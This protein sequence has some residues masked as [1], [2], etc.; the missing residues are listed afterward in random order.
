MVNHNL[1]FKTTI[2]DNIAFFSRHFKQIQVVEL[3]L[4]DEKK[5]WF[6]EQCPIFRWPNKEGNDIH[7]SVSRRFINE[8]KGVH[9]CRWYSFIYIYIYFDIY[10]HIFIYTIYIYIHIF[11]YRAKRFA[12]AM[13][14]H[15]ASMTFRFLFDNEPGFQAKLSVMFLALGRLLGTR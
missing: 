6:T 4:K 3:H 7:T 13:F 14:H 9:P 2:W 15:L 8:S 12:I 5:Q 11:M 1:R 10:T